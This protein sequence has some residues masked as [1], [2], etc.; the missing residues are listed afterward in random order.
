MLCLVCICQHG[1]YGLG[2]EEE[3]VVRLGSGIVKPVLINTFGSGI[4]KLLYHCHMY[5][6]FN[7]NLSK[8][9]QYGMKE[10]CVKKEL[11]QVMGFQ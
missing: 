7:G 8:C 9:F 2:L 4:Y 6:L 10:V 1:R 11:Q 3:E 5:F